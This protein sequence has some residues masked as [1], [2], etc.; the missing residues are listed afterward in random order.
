MQREIINPYPHISY[1]IEITCVHDLF[2]T[3][4]LT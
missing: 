4:A 1:L 2:A 3:A